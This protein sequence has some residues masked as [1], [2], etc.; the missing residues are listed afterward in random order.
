MVDRGEYHIRELKWEQRNELND[1]YY[2]LFP[3]RL[4]SK[5]DGFMFSNEL[6]E[7][8]SV[9]L[10]LTHRENECETIV[11]MSLVC[12]YRAYFFEM[13]PRANIMYFGI[14]SNHRRR[15]LGTD[16]LMFTVAFI[17]QIFDVTVVTLHVAQTNNAAQG[18][19]YSV[20]FT[21]LRSIQNYYFDEP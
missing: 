18:L 17:K 9:P 1:L 5:I 15:H 10:I 11:G 3:E 8:Y 7:P 13:K 6:F 2:K 16:L 14:D 20:G 4:G 21:I 12:L 19:Y